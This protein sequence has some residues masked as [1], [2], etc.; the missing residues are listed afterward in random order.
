MSF[1]S[2]RPQCSWRQ[3]REETKL[4]VSCGT[5]LLVFCCTSQLKNKKNRK[6][7]RG[8]YLLDISWYNSFAAFSRCKSYHLRVGISSYLTMELVRF[9]PWHMRHSPPIG[10]CIW[11]W[12]YNSPTCHL[13]HS[14]LCNLFFWS[15]LLVAPVDLHQGKQEPS[16]ILE[17]KNKLHYETLKIT[18]IICNM[19]ILEIVK[20]T[21]QFH[22][23]SCST[24]FFVGKQYITSKEQR[25]SST[26]HV[27]M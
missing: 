19:P 4:T 2:P 6:K 17:Q 9:D 16:K 7:V 14:L 21:F 15:K 20:L 12:R 27:A 18:F 24:L 25:W 11:L 10:L 3:C 1:V 5:S 13:Y 23:L 8:H 22:A 26:V